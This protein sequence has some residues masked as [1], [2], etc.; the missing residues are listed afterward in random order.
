MAVKSAL[1]IKGGLVQQISVSA[2]SLSVGY[3]AFVNNNEF[4]LRNGAVVV[5][6]GGG[7]TL[8]GFTLTVPA[9]GTAALRN[10]ANTFSADQTFGTSLVIGASS[11]ITGTELRSPNGI[12][13]GNF[14]AANAVLGAYFECYPDSDPSYPGQFYF[15]AG[16]NTNSDIYFAVSGGFVNAMIVKASGAILVGRSSGLT[17]AGDMD[18][19]G[20]LRVGSSIG[21]YGTTPIAK[22]TVTGARGSNAA[23]TSLL[24]ALA[25]LGLITNST[26]T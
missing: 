24:T 2:D 25:N 13:I 12:R 10:V 7:I 16:T 14:T 4:L 1:I 6:G 9:A 15:N 21:F 11:V 22:P 18:V 19:N 23:L 8:G 26:S 17:G 3:S 20:K 5:D